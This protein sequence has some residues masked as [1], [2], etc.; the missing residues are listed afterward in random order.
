MYRCRTNGVGQLNAAGAGHRFPPADAQDEIHVRRRV[1]G[2][3]VVDQLTDSPRQHAARF[4]VQMCAA[5]QQA[6]IGVH[7]SHPAFPLQVIQHMVPL[8]S[9]VARLLDR[10]FIH[11]LRLAYVE[12]AV[13]E[14]LLVLL[15]RHAVQ[16]DGG[17]DT[18]RLEGHGADLI[19][20]A[21]HEQ[22]GCHVVAE[23]PLGE[24]AGIGVQVAAGVAVRVDGAPQGRLAGKQQGVVADHL[25]G[26]AGRG[27]DDG[28]RAP[29]VGAV[30]VDRVDAA[31][32]V[33]HQ[34]QV[35][36]AQP[37]LVRGNGAALGEDDV[38]Q[39]GAALLREA[40]LVEI[41]QRLAFHQRRV[42]QQGVHRHHAGAADA[43]NVDRVA[44]ADGR[45][46]RRFR[47]SVRLKHGRLFGFQAGA[48]LDFHGHEGRAIAVQAG[49]VLV[50]R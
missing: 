44:L 19:G 50:A 48:G 6:L 31:Q 3:L 10:Q 26:R 14:R 30:Q 8:R 12:A 1:G 41:E 32:G 33:Q 7:V 22:V 20:H 40:G 29:G 39:H 37:H 49:V 4:V 47:Q 16:G 18:F 43:G 11:G 15:H 25:A 9:G 38:R 2:V 45:L 27:V 17:L 42:A 13:T 21:E 34:V 36:G 5:F 28:H 46:V 35:R 23:E 24:G